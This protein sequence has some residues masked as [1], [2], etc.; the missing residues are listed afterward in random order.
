MDFIEGCMR[1][2]AWADQEVGGQAVD[3]PG[4]CY[5]NYRKECGRK[6]TTECSYQAYGSVGTSR[7]GEQ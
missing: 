5:G 4:A 6:E 3:K 7:T 1:N 2:M